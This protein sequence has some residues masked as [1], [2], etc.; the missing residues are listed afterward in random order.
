MTGPTATPAEAAPSGRAITVIFVGE[1]GTADDAIPNALERASDRLTVENV[2]D[3]AAVRERVR[4]GRADCLVSRPSAADPDH[5]PFL[6]LVRTEDPQL[7]LFFVTDGRDEA[8]ASD[9]LEAGAT[10]CVSESVALDGTRLATRIERA[11]ERRTE[12]RDLEAAATRFRAFTENA[13]FVVLTADDDGVVRY[14]NDT[15]ETVL[16]YE[17]TELVGERLT[18]LI[19]DRYQN[20][21]REAIARYLETG[22]R[23][24]DWDWIELSA[25]HA[26][27][28]EVPVGISFG[29]AVVDGD[30]LFTAVI[31]DVTDRKRL[32]REREATL[33]R[34]ADAFVS[35]DTDWKY[36]Y[37][38]EQAVELFDRPREE[39]IGAKMRSVFPA[40]VDSEIERQLERAVAD[41]TAV[42][43]TEY[44]GPLEKWLEI[45]AYPSEDG[46][47][48]FVTD[49]SDRIRAEEELEASVTALQALYD[50]STRTDASL[51]EKL[52]DLLDLGCEYLDL[53]YGFMTRIDLDERTQTVVE[54]RS[55]HPLLQRGESCPLSEAYCRKTIKTHELV[56]V[57]NAP[58]EGW[59]G[60]PAYELFELGSY[61]GAKVTVDGTIWGT[62][63]FASSDPREGDG[64]SAAERSL[65]KLMAKWVSY[66][67]ERAQSRETLERQNDRL[68]EFTS[69]V[70]HDLRNP[71]NVAQGSLELARAGDRSQLE[72]C[73]EALDRMETLIEEL[74]RLAE[75]GATTADGEPVSVRELATKAWTTVDTGDA[76]LDVEG[77]PWIEADPDR[78]RQL[79]ENL[80]RN[81]LDHGIPD[82]G[83][84]ADL[85]VSVGDCEDGIY[86]ADTGRGIPPDE[87]EEVFDV[88]YTTAEDG[89]GFGLG[90]VTRVAEAHGWDL[91]VTESESGGARFEL[92]GVARP[93]EG[94]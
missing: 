76:A 8:T 89:T 38:N 82:G 93:R 2:T 62:L 1:G 52:P 7:P 45:R 3:E 92:T 59:T 6:E 23:G 18:T 35:V 56:T 74:L 55:D 77:E 10:G 42:S 71:L 86:V 28:H 88:G 47:S 85:T 41:Q 69:V 24:L 19:P 15:V 78:F 84:S 79:L 25:R 44:A 70:S 46:L 72:A 66:E 29:E 80:F 63:C 31:R 30:H 60:D 5:C 61:V 37:V 51:E 90:I 68:Q 49:V 58:D 32:E 65:V 33:E 94:R 12:R 48:I 13:S 67:T 57:A 43:F 75:Q 20:R 26:E 87:R 11:I 34:I 83:T 39:L 21:H 64:F 40:I 53:S 22:E 16:G 9:L 73:E 14:A 81:A 27:G 4:T 54:S 50:I 91:A 36:T 17:P